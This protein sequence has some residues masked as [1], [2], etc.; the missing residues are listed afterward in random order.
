M[1]KNTP[2]LIVCLALFAGG[3]ILPVAAAPSSQTPAS[4]A[5]EQADARLLQAAASATEPG[6]PALVAKPEIAK[7]L[8][9]HE[10]LRRCS[11]QALAG[12]A[13]KPQGKA[14]LDLF[15]DNQSWME[16]F[17]CNG[18]VGDADVSLG[19]LAD[20]W[21]SDPDCAKIP[22]YREL[23]TATALAYTAPCQRPRDDKTPGAPVARYTFF[24]RS[25]KAGK[26]HPSFEALKAWEMTYLVCCIADN[27]S[28]AW[29]QDNL[30]IPL[31]RFSGAEGCTPYLA[32]NVF[33][34][35]VM[36]WS[37][38]PGYHGPWALGGQNLAENYYR[39]SGVCGT[40]SNFASYVSVSRGVVAFPV[41]QNGHCAYAV[42]PAPH[43]WV[44]GFGGPGGIS[45][46]HYGNLSPVCGQLADAIF[47]QPD[48]VLASRRLAWLGALLKDTDVPKA[49]AALRAA[50]QA[51]SLNAEAW[52]DYSDLL[53]ATEAQLPVDWK[54]A[55]QELIQSD[56]FRLYACGS[57][58]KQ[59]DEMYNRA[60]K[61]LSGEEKLAA[62]S[63]AYA[64]CA[65]CYAQFT[66][67]DLLE[68]H[69]R[70]LPTEELRVQFGKALLG[71]MWKCWGFDET[72][73]WVNQHFAK[74]PGGAAHM[75][76]I[77]SQSFDTRSPTRTQAWRMGQLVSQVEDLFDQP[78]AMH[79][80]DMLEKNGWEALVS[81]S[82]NLKNQREICKKIPAHPPLPG[83]LLSKGGILHLSSN[84]GDPDGLLLHRSMLTEAGGFLQT[85]PQKN[86]SVT[87][88]LGKPGALTGIVITNH[89]DGGK[90]NGRAFP[91]AI[92]VSDDN[93]TWTPVTTLTKHEDVWTVNLEGKGFKA[94]YVK[95]ESLRER[96]YLFLRQILVYGNPSK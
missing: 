57:G 11:R 93:K 67:E 12:I 63:N 70:S 9:R 19:H 36:T 26:L 85:A 37:P 44:G 15:L 34:N 45:Q 13:Q 47:T 29:L 60:A 5:H 91:L 94:Q 49:R 86:P 69:Y 35:N 92:S 89:F 66:F 76:E 46:G 58:L 8:V 68:K 77:L 32:T 62:L 18:P 82:D 21:A 80:M 78:G 22:L 96:E 23:A 51:Q 41:G 90:W 52:Q 40:Q 28:L 6:M 73:G 43:N 71:A 50:T 84:S 59:F 48:A 61:R 81:A 55:M 30:H 79:A 27:E 24:K 17:F 39:H 72:L 65:P 1:H 16:S 14:F 56:S 4:P 83:E 33:G 88:R 42:R 64:A 3:N 75:L 53:A 25:H 95:L 2:L 10:I 38:A 87:V 20:I 31:S 74:K 54:A 7:A